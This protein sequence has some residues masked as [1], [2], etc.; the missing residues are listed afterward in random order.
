MTYVSMQQF[1]GIFIK[2]FS[3]A[4]NLGFIFIFGV[5]CGF[6]YCSSYLHCDWRTAEEL[7]IGD[8]RILSKIKRYK[9]K[10]AQNP[11]LAEVFIVMFQCLL[12]E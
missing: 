10:R 7:L 6:V 11:Y 8:K 4:D 12:H 1:T 2:H 3:T 9:L 5:A